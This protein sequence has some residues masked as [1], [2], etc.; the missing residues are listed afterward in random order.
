MGRRSLKKVQ[1]Y[2]QLQS[3]HDKIEAPAFFQI[4]CPAVLTC[5][6]FTAG[7]SNTATRIP[8]QLCNNLTSQHF[9]ALENNR[10]VTTLLLQTQHRVQLR[11]ETG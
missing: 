4:A 3:L 8:K 9:Q 5:Y 7:W 2:Q 6:L 11:V 1:E 10:H